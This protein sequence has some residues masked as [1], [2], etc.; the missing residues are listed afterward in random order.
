MPINEML[1]MYDIRGIQ[2]YI[3][4]T[5]AVKEIIGASKI[6]DDIIINGFKEYVNSLDEAE[7]QYYYLDWKHDDH[8]KFLKDNTV[9]MQVMFVGGGNAYVL[10]RN[11]DVASKVNKYIGK[12][13]LEHTYS[14]HV[15]IA[16]VDKTDSYRDDYRDINNKMRDIKARMPESIPVGALPFVETDSITG[17]PL[18]RLGD[19]EKLCTESYLKQEAFKTLKDVNEK[20]FDNMVT[21]KGDNSTLALV[22]M[23]GNSLGKRIMKIM[24]GIDDYPSAIKKMR[25]LSMGIDDTFKKA[26]ESMEDWMDT[27]DKYF[28][29]KKNKKHRKIVLAGDDICFVCNPK[30][31]LGALDHFLKNL[32]EQDVSFIKKD[33]NDK[34]IFSACA[35]VAFFNSHF[36]F[37]DAYKVAEAC[38]DNAKKMAKTKECCNDNLVGNFIDFQMCT[39]INASDLDA[40]RDKHYRVNNE[41][42]INRPYY[43]DV[44]N[45]M[46]LNDKNMKYSIKGLYEKLEILTSSKTPRSI[47]KEIRGVI[48]QGANEIKKE[49]SYLDSRKYDQFNDLEEKKSVWYDACELMD[50]VLKEG[51]LDENRN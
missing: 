35:G 26:Y 10:Y 20:I 13:V 34:P 23:D 4:K 38:C 29:N 5:N 2:N 9:L 17:Y 32:N 50:F 42:F 36:P 37:S 19:H 27:Q 28:E 47:A 14:L 46:N 16:M 12:Y 3:F 51:N 15:A 33:D 7:R 11:K 31:V 22:H 25:T 44:N 1:A 40:Y 49:I 39:N 21:K 6:V 24:Q 41:K 43:V 45:D 30:L 48:P 18:T 8:E